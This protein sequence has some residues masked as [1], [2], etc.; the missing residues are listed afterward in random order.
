MWIGLLHLGLDGA[1]WLIEALREARAAGTLR[2][3]RLTDLLARVLE[4]GHPV[5]VVY[6]RGG[7]VN[8]NDLA[9]LIDA[10]GL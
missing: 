5:R 7:W 10:S 1:G 6:S 2:A 9:D 4:R 3:A 8:V